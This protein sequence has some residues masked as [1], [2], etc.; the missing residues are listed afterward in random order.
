[1]TFSASRKSDDFTGSAAIRSASGSRASDSEVVTARHQRKPS[2]RSTSPSG[3][4]DNQGRI[5]TSGTQQERPPCST[6]CVIH[7][8]F[9]IRSNGSIG[10]TV[11]DANGNAI[12]WTTDVIVAQVI[13]RVMNENEGLLVAAPRRLLE[14]TLQSGT[15]PEC[16]RQKDKR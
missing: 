9:T 12:A 2:T 15:Q 16:E 11:L 8:P 5:T 4:A 14:M 7:G 6:A 3:Q 1:M 13:C 10:Q